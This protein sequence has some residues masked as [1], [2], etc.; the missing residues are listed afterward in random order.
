MI[1]YQTL[2]N[3]ISLASIPVSAAEA[4]GIITGSLCANPHDEKGQWLQLILGAKDLGQAKE[5]G[6]TVKKL[7]SAYSEARISLKDGDF[8]HDLLLPDDSAPIQARV[9]AVADW[10]KGFILGLMENGLKEPSSLSGDAGEFM[11]DLMAIS[12]VTPDD[13]DDLEGQEKSLA[14]LTEYVRIGVR[15]VYEELNPILTEQAAVTKH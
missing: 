8:A 2:T 14:E 7:V 3:A 5:Y 15:L 13:D 4:H 1:D 12:E 9:E 10:C 6:E 11:Q